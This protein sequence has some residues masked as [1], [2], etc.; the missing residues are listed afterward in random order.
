[1]N[2]K[3]NQK[4]PDETPEFKPYHRKWNGNGL[5]MISNRIGGAFGYT[6]RQ[7]NRTTE[8]TNREN[9]IAL[10]KAKAARMALPKK[11]TPST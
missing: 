10:E 2:K 5:H 4:S 1:M 9:R 7:W 11:T 8:K 6:K 3:E